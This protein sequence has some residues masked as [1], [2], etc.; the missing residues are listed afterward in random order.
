MKFGGTLRNA[1]NDVALTFI[2]M[3]TF[4]F[5]T[6][7][8]KSR[9]VCGS[10]CCLPRENI[11]GNYSEVFEY[12]VMKIRLRIMSRIGKVS[13]VCPCQHSPVVSC[14]GLQ[15]LRDP[16]EEEPDNGWMETNWP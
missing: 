15:L 1:V 3:K 4:L 16:S 7:A 12:G 8:N 2:N 11:T 13:R 14:D 10:G 5:F 9:S 6:Q